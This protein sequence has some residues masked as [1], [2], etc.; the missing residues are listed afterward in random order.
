MYPTA[1]SNFKKIAVAIAFSPRREAV[2]FEA[3]R[4]RE[5]YDAELILIHVGEKQEH[6]LVQLDA[7][8]DDYKIP[9][10]KVHI[11]WTTGDPATKIVETCRTEQV[12]LLIAG[13]LKRE[14]L[15]RYYLGSVARHI[16]REAPCSVL[17]FTEPTRKS[18]SFQQI[19]VSANPYETTDLALY[20]AVK[21]A[22]KE[23]AKQLHIIREIS[24]DW[25]LADVPE[26]PSEQEVVRETEKIEKTLQEVVKTKKLVI[27]INVAAAKKGRAIA[28]A[29]QTHHADLIVLPAPKHRWKFFDRFFNNELNYILADL[30]TNLLL[31][32]KTG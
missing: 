16:T 29:A 1:F 27:N 19:I 3:K 9:L 17:I 25:S 5:L 8:I 31:V 6:K 12:D 10:D 26:P 23:K 20:H 13:A 4:L 30:P 2:L 11:C 28:L 24:P 21:L 7:L 14:N 15:F 18:R 22:R 32:K